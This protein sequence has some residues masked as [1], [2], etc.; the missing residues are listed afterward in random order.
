MITDHLD[1]KVSLLVSQ[2]F[3]SSCFFKNFIPVLDYLC[4]RCEEGRSV[5][6]DDKE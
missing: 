2:F 1:V 4:M 3:A 6:L 5:L